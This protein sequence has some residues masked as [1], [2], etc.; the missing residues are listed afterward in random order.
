MNRKEFMERLE[1]LL[2]DIS[3]SEREEALQFYNDYFDDAGPENEDQVIAELK[4]PEQVAKK[5]KVEL[6]DGV[7]E[8]TEHGYQDSGFRENQEVAARESQTQQAASQKKQGV[9]GWKILAIILLCILLVPVIIPIGLTILAAI[10]AVVIGA[11]ALVAALAI[12]GFAVLLTGLV[13]IGIGLVQMVVAAPLGIALA[14]VGCI[15][16][17]IGIPLFMAGIWCCVKT[18]PWLIRSF[19]AICR[20]PL[21]KAGVLR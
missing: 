19:V 1:K 6:S 15:V 10:A 2:R 7:T 9:N 20:F 16:F 21:R 18:I 8:Y 13:L 3:D 4:S 12:I 14:G 11:F 5:I 17:A